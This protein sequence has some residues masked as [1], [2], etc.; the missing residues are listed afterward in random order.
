MPFRHGDVERSAETHPLL[1]NRA[2]FGDIGL[3]QGISIH[4]D[5]STRVHGDLVSTHSDN[6]LDIGITSR[7]TKTG[8][9]SQERKV[10]QNTTERWWW[11]SSF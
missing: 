3:I 8:N 1:I 7:V 5:F 6:P 9:Q 10:G 11:A 2:V 4:P